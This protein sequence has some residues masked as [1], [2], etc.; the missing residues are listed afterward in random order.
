MALLKNLEWDKGLETGNEIID[1]Q[2]RELVR[3]TG[4]LVEACAED[5]SSEVLGGALAFLADYTVRHFADEEALQL[6]C[7]FPEY[8]AHK[9]LHE[10]FKVTVGE[11]A[12][13]YA[14]EG[15]TEV[16]ASAV[17]TVVIRWLLNHIKQEDFK[18][19]EFIHSKA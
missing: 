15:S 17:D 2:H 13:R 9:K 19:A 14:E 8:E 12:A 11:L 4:V 1:N 16:L 7:G 3:L 5:K 18:I 6:E 10:D